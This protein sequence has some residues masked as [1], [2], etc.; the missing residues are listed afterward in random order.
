MT[1]SPIW[2][3]PSKNLTV[4]L[5]VVPSEFVTVAVSVTVSPAPGARLSAE[6]V[7][8][9]VAPTALGEAAPKTAQQASAI[10]HS[11][12]ARGPSRRSFIRCLT[13]S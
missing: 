8:V 12:I 6:R 5:G 13:L 2:T 1:G 9:W 10:A 11:T 7:I 3:V 4:P